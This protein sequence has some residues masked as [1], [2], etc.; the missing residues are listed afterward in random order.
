S[1]AGGNVMILLSGRDMRQLLKPPAVIEA[2]R[3][4][5]QALANNRSEQGRSFAFA[6]EGGSAHV[7][8]GL[9]PGSRTALAAKINVNLPD[10]DRL[11][12]LATIHGSGGLSG[13]VH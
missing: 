5:Y 4:A 10:N 12:G 6:I 8:A 9:L 11:R 2:L 7:K 3:E 13:G 1:P